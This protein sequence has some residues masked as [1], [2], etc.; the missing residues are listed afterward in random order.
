MT[1]L[2]SYDFCGYLHLSDILGTINDT[3][4]RLQCVDDVMADIDY[5]TCDCKAACNE[6]DYD[7]DVSQT[8]W[9]HH[10]HHLTFYTTYIIP[11]V[12]DR[13]R[14]IDVHACVLYL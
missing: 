13:Q 12:P 11:S 10:S 8:S 14:F 2:D 3:V 1:D 6:V 9:P 5:D 4:A 7:T